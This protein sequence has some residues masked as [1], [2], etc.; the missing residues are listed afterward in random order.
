MEY[1]TFGPGREP[2]EDFTSE[3]EAFCALDDVQREA[4]ALWFQSTSDFDTYPTE[5]PPSILASTLL[6]EQFRKTASP[7]RF[8]LDTW[9][10]RSLELADIERDLL[11]LGLNQGQITVVVAFLGRLSS[12]KERIWVDRREGNA[13]VVGLPT[14]NDAN[15]LWDARP[16]F[17]GESYYYFGTDGEEGRYNQCLGLTCM[18]IMELMTVDS[19]ETK[20]RLAVQMNENTFKRFLRAMNRAN[21]QLESLKDF[22]KPVTRA[23][24]DTQS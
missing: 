10:E 1:K 9:Y 14:V 24:T 11:L 18:A 15:I 20:Q 3:L 17:G 12:L 19:N 22:L 4:L 2:Y 7:I 8:L 16:F 5:L 21:D 23:P 13:Q 6:P